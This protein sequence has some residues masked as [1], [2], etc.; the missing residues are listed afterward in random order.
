MVILI[1]IIALGR[2]RFLGN[3]MVTKWMAFYNRN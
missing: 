3:S 1:L 2:D